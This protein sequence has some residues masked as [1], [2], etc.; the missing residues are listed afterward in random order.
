[1]SILEQMVAG[2]AED[3]HYQE[4]EAEAEDIHKLEAVEGDKVQGLNQHASL[5]SL[6]L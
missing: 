1:M 2:R 5:F 6:F 3:S 4:E